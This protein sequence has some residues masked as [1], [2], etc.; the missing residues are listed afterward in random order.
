M[1]KQIAKGFLCVGLGSPWGLAAAVFAFATSTTSALAQVPA[2]LPEQDG[3][4]MQWVI[5]G[6][7]AVIVCA[8]GFL[9]SKRSHLN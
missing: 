7:L 1:K 6:G 2:R 9:S 4:Y 8:T 5:F 3:G